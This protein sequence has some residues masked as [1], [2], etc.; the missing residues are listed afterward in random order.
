MR[1][2][3]TILKE[4]LENSGNAFFYTPSIYQ[5]GKCFLFKEAMHEISLSDVENFLLQIDSKIAADSCGH[6]ILPYELGYTFE[7]SLNKLIDQNSEEIINEKTKAFFFEKN[8]V[9]EFSAGEIKISPQKKSRAKKIKLDEDYESYRKKILEIKERILEGDTYQA[10]FTLRGEFDFHGD[11]I[12]LFTELVHKQSAQFCAFINLGT[13]ILI[14]ISPEL[15]FE[16]NGE[17]IITRPMKGTISRGINYHEDA[18]QKYI[19][20]SSEKDRAENIMIV[21]LLRNDLGKICEFN[22][23]TAKNLFLIEKY[24]SVFQMVSEVKGM[25]KEGFTFSSII[26][27]IFPCGSVTGAPKIRTMEIIHELENTPRGIYTGAIGIVSKERMIFNVA[28]RT[29]ELDLEKQKGSIG[30]GSGIVADSK[31]R[32]EFNECKLKGNFFTSS[33]KSFYIFETM[34]VEDWKIY[35]F[36]EHL[37]RMCNSANYFLFDFEEKAIRNAIEM[38]VAKSFSPHQYKLKMMLDKWGNISFHPT[39]LE[40]LPA[41]IVINI[42]RKRISSR[43]KF[44]YFKTSRREEYDKAIVKNQRTNIFETIF[45]NERNEIAEG[46]FTNIFIRENEHLITP[47]LNSGLLAGV[48]RNHLLNSKK[49]IE[50]RFLTISDL[51]YAEEIILVNSVRKEIKVDKFYFTENEYKK[52]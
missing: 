10:N 23:I 11:A 17:E 34:L 1:E 33:Y 40:K 31:P 26:K 20:Q 12:D 9:K 29:I 13:K 30:I 21:D 14:S 18:V 8:N 41:E 38:E 4:V 2:L 37:K 7:K 28:I 52:Y 44:Q 45:L 51:I 32:S 46:A 19:L 24:E 5:N 50:E 36:E 15:F 49:N 43:N 39:E 47:P 25:L 35:L 3:K 6:V 42:S 16:V 22:S 48:Y 27:N